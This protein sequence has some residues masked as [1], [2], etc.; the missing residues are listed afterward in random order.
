MKKF[1]READQRICTKFLRFITGAD[2]ITSSIN[3][4]FNSI[5]DGFSRSPV[6]HTCTNTLDLPLT[7][8][9]FID[10]RCELTS[11]L[12]SNVWVMDLA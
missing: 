10:L 5:Q 7:Y 2:I 9:S 3:V 4:N 11:L 1:I 6:A 12:S 8:D